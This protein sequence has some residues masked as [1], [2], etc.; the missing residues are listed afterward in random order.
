M[1]L[2]KLFIVV[3]VVLALRPL[4]IYFYDS[5]KLRK[6]PNQ[7]LLSGVTNLASM[8]ERLRR[9]RTRELYLQHQKHPVIRAAPNI[10]SFR[11]VKAIKDIYG[12]G[13][14]CQKHEMYKLQNGEGHM[15]ILNVIDRE[16]H[17]RK[18]RMLS[19][20]FSTKNLESWEFKITD[21]VEKLVAQL[22]R[23]AHA[24]SWNNSPNQPNTSMVDLRYWF[25]LF[26]VDAIADIALSERLGMLESGSDVVKVSGPREENRTHRFIADMHEAARVKSKIIGT[27]D[28]YNVL[29]QV[30]I[31][32]SSRCRSQWDCGGNVGQIVSHLASK[33]LQRYED[34]ESIDDFLSCLIKDK[35][36]KSRDLDMGELKAETNILLDAGSETTAIALTHLLYYLIKNPNCFLKLRKEVSEAITGDKVAPY[37]KVKS[38]PY[39]K[40]CIEESLRLSPPLPRGLERVTPPAGA[41]IMGEFIPGNVGVSVPA[42]VAHRDPDVFPEP[43]AFMPERW[44]NNENIGKMRDAFIPFSAG[45]RACIGRNITMIEQ[46]ILIATLVYRY[47]FSLPSPDWTLQNEEAFNLWPVDLPVK[48]WKRDLET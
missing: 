36:G 2:E 42:Y 40:A 17:N 12:F 46:Q 5:K 41:H 4:V 23:R 7:N 19:H 22:D 26:T 48:V 11:D 10:L 29:K 45:G 27:L 38:L 9:F 8:R 28:W 25:N 18:R 20:A 13:S 31:F 35:A 43:E 37:A 33:R 14:S 16:D 44:F 32:F 34:G 39:L 24:P 30:T 21:K 1:V 15:N 3:F 6:Y 47:D